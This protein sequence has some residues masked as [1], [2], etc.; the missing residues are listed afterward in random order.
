M[1]DSKLSPLLG[2]RNICLHIW[3]SHGDVV[4]FDVSSTAALLY[5][6]LTV[7]GHFSV[8]HC[9]NPDLSPS[10]QLPFLTHGLHHVS[11]LSAI[12]AYVRKLRNAHNLDGHLT[13]VQTAQLTARIAHVE[14]SYGDLVN[15]MLY[16]LQEN[17]SSVTAPALV[18]M[19]PVP[20]RYYVPSRVRKSHKPRLE[21]AGL[22]HVPE[23]EGEPEEPRRVLGRR[24]KQH[25]PNEA[26]KFKTA[27]ER[28]NVVE[29]ARA[30]FDVYDRLLG[31]H[32]FFTG[33]E[34]PTTLDVVFA[35][36]THLLLNL[37]FPDPLVSSVLTGSYP[38]LAAH[39]AAVLRIALPD[40]AHFPPVVQKSWSYSLR[41]LI[42]WPRAPPRRKSPSTVLAN[43]PEVQ[44]EEWRYR[45]WRWGFIGA[46]VLIAAAYIQF[47][48]ITIVIQDGS[49]RARLPLRG[50][51]PPDDVE[52][53]EAA[54]GEEEEEEGA[55]AEE[56][57]EE[58]EAE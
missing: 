8:T 56:T 12:I 47:A 5:L 4:S 46:S 14:S 19:L 50:G 25:A 27:F 57:E 2:A 43:A 15:H 9:A 30:V 44:K 55:E 58:E 24:K 1:S 52:E 16:S 51:P 3:P 32:Q 39:H 54:E 26:H 28:E 23:V 20:Q 49:A 21:A 17:W 29:K 31:D 40:P 11:G 48:A 18:S 33:S 7:P 38:R 35:A 45:L 36:H 42:P 13:S 41:Y 53:A 22:W 37:P 34:T 6:Q 10:G